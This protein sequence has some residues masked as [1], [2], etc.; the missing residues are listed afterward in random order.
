MS[1]RKRRANHTKLLCA[2]SVRFHKVFAAAFGIH[3]LWVVPVKECAARMRRNQIVVVPIFLCH[4]IIVTILTC[5]FFSFIHNNLIK[6]NNI[7]Y[8]NY[9]TGLTKS[10]CIK[11]RINPR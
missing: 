6:M 4:A 9:N 11:D 1:R 7:I 3:V 5:L 8:D 10:Q 2:A